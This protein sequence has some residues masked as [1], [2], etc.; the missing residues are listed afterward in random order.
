VLLDLGDQFVKLPTFALAN[1]EKTNADYVPLVNGL[2]DACNEEGQTVKVK[3]NFDTAVDPDRIAIFGP[4]LATVP[5]QIQNAP[6]QPDGWVEQV[7]SGT[8]IHVMS[9]FFAAF[10]PLRWRSDCIVFGRHS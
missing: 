1:V 9:R 6:A 5:T 7:Q 4:E 8:A 2:S 10:G 3:L